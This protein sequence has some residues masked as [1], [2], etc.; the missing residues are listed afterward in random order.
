M[1]SRWFAASGKLL[2]MDGQGPSCWL[3]AAGQTHD[4]L[5]SICMAIPGEWQRAQLSAD[6]CR[7]EITVHGKG[8]TSGRIARSCG[9]GWTTEAR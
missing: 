5:Q 6:L 1:T 8:G 3:V 9:S 4:D 7:R 2:R